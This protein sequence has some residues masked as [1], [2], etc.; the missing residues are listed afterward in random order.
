MP[1]E[2]LIGKV[3]WPGRKKDDPSPIIYFSGNNGIVGNAETGE[4]SAE[5]TIFRSTNWRFRCLSYHY[6]MKE[7][8]AKRALDFNLANGIGVFMDSGAF[9]L[10][11]DQTCTWKS[12]GAYAKTYGAFLDTY[13]NKVH[14]YAGLDW[15]RDAETSWQ[16]HAMMQKLGYY[17][18]PVF[19]GNDH[20]DEFKKLLDV[21]FPLIAMAKPGKQWS[22]NAWLVGQDLRRVYDQIHHLAGQYKCAL[23]GLAQT[24][25]MMFSYPWYS[26]DSTNWLA[27]GRN[28]QLFSIEPRTGRIQTTFLGPQLHRNKIKDPHKKFVS[29]EWEA[30]DE[31]T[32]K[33][34]AANA[35]RFGLTVQILLT[36]YL[37][38]NAYNVLILQEAVAAGTFAHHGPK[39]TKVLI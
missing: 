30:L 2:K 21:G 26:V 39:F 5:E 29:P 33:R 6:W 34:I 10:Q 1:R 9:T 28:G 31:Q 32:R 15:K 27:G 24:G 19:H 22:P 25:R 14:W 16:A 38:R 12:V 8:R 13:R 17:P 4:L 35:K 20:I 11:R 37:M 23:H 18:V 7:T 3:D 36:D